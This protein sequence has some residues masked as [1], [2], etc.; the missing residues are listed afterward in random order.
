A[1]PHF[2][3]F[4]NMVEG[5]EEERNR[6]KKDLALAFKYLISYHELV[7][8]DQNARSEWLKKGLALLPNNKD[9]AQIAT[10]ETDDSPNQ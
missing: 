10:A 1:K 2:E 6:Y 9:L 8:K 4:I 3:Q 7:T 5:K